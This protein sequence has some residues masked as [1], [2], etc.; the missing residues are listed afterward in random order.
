MPDKKISSLTELGE[1]PASL[2]EFV[3]VDKSDTSMS[4]DGTTKKVQ[5]Q[6]LTISDASTT[7]KG[8]VELATDAEANTNTDTVR[9]ITPS[10]GQSLVA[11]AT[12]VAASKT[13]PVDADYLPVI[14][15]ASSNVLKKLTW[16]NLKATLLTYFDSVTTTLTNK[17]ITS[18]TNTISTATLNNPYKFYVYRNAAANTANAAFTV[19]NFDTESFDTGNNVSS[20][21]FTVPVDGF[22][23]LNARVGVNNT[24]N[25]INIISIFVNGAE[26]V[27]GSDL[28][29]TGISGSTV[30]AT[31]Y[32]TASQTVDVRIFAT[33]VYALDAGSEGLTH[34]SGFLVSR[35]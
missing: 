22:Y 20:G 23:H 21:V 8:K 34:F 2:D 18:T 15:S 16:A 28:R 3:V 14:D 7:V 1:A 17:T 29:F 11:G 13:T 27:R 30:G 35:T 25:A 33:G 24:S 9:A 32:L 5:A 12:T 10:N 4:A 6:Y 31:L 19:V 26:K